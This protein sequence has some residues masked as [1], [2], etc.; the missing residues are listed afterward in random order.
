VNIL[1]DFIHYIEYYNTNY[2][3]LQNVI[4]AKEKHWKLNLKTIIDSDDQNW[5]R[6]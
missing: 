5:S 2:K 1:T 4:K 3:E 6:F